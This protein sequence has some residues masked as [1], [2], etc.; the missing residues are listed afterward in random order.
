VDFD[1]LIAAIPLD[2][3][4]LMDSGFQAPIQLRLGVRFL[5]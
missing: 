3:R 2:P 4:F 1:P 5:F